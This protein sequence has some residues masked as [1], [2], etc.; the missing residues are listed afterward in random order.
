MALYEKY[1]E[2]WN[3]IIKKLEVEADEQINTIIKK[4]K[5][6]SGTKD[7]K[8]NIRV[9]GS[10]VSKEPGRKRTKVNG[11]KSNGINKDSKENIS[12]ESKIYTKDIGNNHENEVIE[13]VPRKINGK[14]V[15]VP[16]KAVNKGNANST[17]I[18][19]GKRKSTEKLKKIKKDDVEIKDGQ[20]NEE[21][22]N[23]KTKNDFIKSCDNED[24]V[25]TEDQFIK[26]TYIKDDEIEKD[27]KNDD[28]IEKDIKN[29]DEIEKDIKKECEITK[30]D[31]IIKNELLDEIENDINNQGYKTIV[32]EKEVTIKPIEEKNIKLNNLLKQL[33]YKQKLKEM[34]ASTSSKISGSDNQ[35]KILETLKDL[36]PRKK[37]IKETQLSELSQTSSYIHSKIPKPSLSLNRP[38]NDISEKPIQHKFESPNSLYKTI[39]DNKLKKSPFKQPYIKFDPIIYKPKTI[40]PFIDPEDESKVTPPFDIPLWAKDPK[41]DYITKKQSH[42][43]IEKYFNLLNSEVNVIKMFPD[44][45][46]ITNDSPNK[47]QKHYK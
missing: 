3:N 30:D 34:N 45:K 46:N 10:N 15:R 22:S 28:E 40:L 31:E 13:Y 36:T 4:Y 11:K 25:K 8:I 29:D 39:I 2:E 24:K 42:E 21:I 38:G 35:S 33:K 5:Q 6:I 17:A 43:E 32:I 18:K 47:L 7:K 19:D 16:K 23:E 27:I 41:I 14:I 20:I 1:R 26:S 9:L 12:E 44:N 37:A